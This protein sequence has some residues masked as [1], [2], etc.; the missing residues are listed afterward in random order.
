MIMNWKDIAGRINKELVKFRRYGM[1]C[2][3]IL[4]G[5]K[6]YEEFEKLDNTDSTDDEFTK[7]AWSVTLIKVDQ[8]SYLAGAYMPTEEELQQKRLEELSS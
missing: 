6:E 5:R 2:T 8:D 4:V 7:D 3:H 1:T